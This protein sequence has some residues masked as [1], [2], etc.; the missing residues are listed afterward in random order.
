MIDLDGF[1]H[2]L[3]RKGF[4]EAAINRI[5]QELV[6]ACPWIANP[7]GQIGDSEAEVRF[8]QLE[9]FF[10]SH[11]L[12]VH[13]LFEP[14]VDGEQWDRVYQ[15]VVKTLGSFGSNDELGEGDFWIIEDF[16]GTPEVLVEVLNEKVVTDSMRQA[17]RRFLK[18]EAPNFSVIIREVKKADAA[19]E[20]I[21]A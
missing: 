19:D 10:A 17:L 18:Q 15:G 3:T 20:V 9:A 21:T 12:A 5:A 8:G 7:A 11:G 13:D 16:Y 6:T 1:K 2:L 4:G 14:Q